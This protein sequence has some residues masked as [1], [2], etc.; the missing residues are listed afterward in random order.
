MSTNM[1][2]RELLAADAALMLGVAEAHDVAAALQRYW[3][4]REGT[5]ASLLSEL[6]H[7]ARL[8][9]DALTRIRAE[10]ERLVGEAGGDAK[11]A[12]TRHGGL[13]RSLHVALGQG[14]ANLTH[15]LS[16]LGIQI[17]AP[18]RA[19]PPDRYVGFEAAG[20]GGMGVVYA[21]LDTEMNRNV[22]FKMVRPHAERRGPR[23]GRDPTER[24]AAGAVLSACS[25]ASRG[26]KRVCGSTSNDRL[27]T[28]SAL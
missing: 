19:L 25:P 10:V 3:A 18:L 5:E 14:G 27:R 23:H 4:K 2:F 16:V 26:R 8:S 24:H 17:R 21:A 13:D 22:A 6:A 15:A 20:I 11:V 7:I 1:E 12:L 28:L 9:P